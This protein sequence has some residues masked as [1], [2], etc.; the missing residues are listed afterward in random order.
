MAHEE[1]DAAYLEDGSV[2]YGGALHYEKALSVLTSRIE[3]IIQE[4][5]TDGQNLSVNYIQRLLTRSLEDAEERVT[6]L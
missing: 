4:I 1:L 5:E 3:A 6:L 2:Q